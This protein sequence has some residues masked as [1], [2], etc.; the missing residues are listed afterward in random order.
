MCINRQT[1]YIIHRKN[2]QTQQQLL[3]NVTPQPY[4][5]ASVYLSR[6]RGPEMKS[7]LNPFATSSSVV[8]SDYF[9]ASRRSA[10]GGAV[11]I[12]GLS[13]SLRASL[14][15]LL[16]PRCFFPYSSVRAR[17]FLARGCSCRERERERERDAY[18]RGAVEVRHWGD[19]FMVYRAQ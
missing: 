3:I 14:L 17:E 2:K 7:R 8:V 4:L 11:F 13:Y 9:I 5:V 6:G 18:R 10:S 19:I 16:P 1:L 15:L 12:D